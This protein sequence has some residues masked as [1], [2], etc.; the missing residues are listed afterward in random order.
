MTVT[1]DLGWLAAQIIR[2]ATVDPGPAA[3]IEHAHGTGLKNHRT[4]VDRNNAQLFA[5]AA[6]RRQRGDIDRGNTSRDSCCADDE[7]RQGDERS[8]KRS[9]LSS[10]AASTASARFTNGRSIIRP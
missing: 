4:I 10:A 8:H 5:V 1:N 2:P 3:H 7:R 6:D 9:L